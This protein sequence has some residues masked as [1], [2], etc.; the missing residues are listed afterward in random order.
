[1]A[2][3]DTFDYEKYWRG[4]E[5]EDQS[6]RIALK[7]LLPNQQTYTSILEIGCGFGRLVSCYYP[8]FKKCI[9]AD[10]STKLLSRAKEN[11]KDLKKLDFICASSS[12]IPLKSN[13]LDF[14]L[15]V[16]VCHHLPDLEPSIKEIDRVLKPGG[17]LVLEFANKINLKARLRAF[18][19]GDFNFS[20][21][22]FPLDLRSLGKRNPKYIN[23]SSHHPLFILKILKRNGFIV[24]KTLSVSNFR[25]S[26]F[27]KFIPLKILLKLEDFTQGFLGKF[28]FGPSIF[29][30][31]QKSK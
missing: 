15:M 29:L 9:L 25:L 4:R 13:S 27:K 28:F 26:I 30:L 20:K 6:E 1:M 19:R 22:L 16:R 3:Y 24:Q 11:F 10:P 12:K 18:L 21:S 8:Y 17:F 31:C 2:Y 7:K 14:C 23:F 5:Y